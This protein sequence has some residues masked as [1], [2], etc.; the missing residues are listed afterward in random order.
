MVPREDKHARTEIVIRAW[1]E[2]ED[3]AEEDFRGSLS[4]IE[5]DHNAHFV[6]LD[7]LFSRLLNLMKRTLNGTSRP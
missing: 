3:A 1:R 6:G 4:T 7:Q 5:G 2:N